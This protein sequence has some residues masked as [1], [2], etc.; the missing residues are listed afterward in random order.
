V[1]DLDPA[2]FLERRT[3]PIANSLLLAVL[4][5]TIDVHVDA[6]DSLT[7]VSIAD[8]LVLLLVALSLT[9][10][11][12]LE[13]IRIN[14]NKREEREKDLGGVHDA[15]HNSTGVVSVDVGDVVPIRVQELRPLLVSDFAFIFKPRLDILT[16]DDIK[17]RLG[18]V[19]HHEVAL[20]AHILIRR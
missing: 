6:Q 13:Q 16:S 11:H 15:L 14:Y 18:L 7:A 12:Q 9:E 5:E 17:N 1:S 2:I 8:L 10:T 20:V 3:A 19:K 4:F